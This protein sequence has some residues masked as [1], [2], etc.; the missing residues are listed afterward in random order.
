MVGRAN[1]PRSPSSS[2]TWSTPSKFCLRRKHIEDL[3]IQ[4][5]WKDHGCMKT[6]Q[7]YIDRTHRHSST[8]KFRKR[9]R[10]V[11]LKGVISHS[12]PARKQ[13]LS[14]VLELIC[15]L[16][17]TMP[18]KTT[19]EDCSKSRLKHYTNHTNPLRLSVLCGW[20][21]MEWRFGTSS[22]PSQLNVWQIWWCD[23]WRQIEVSVR[24]CTARIKL[25]RCQIAMK[26][27]KK[28]SSTDGN[29]SKIP[30]T[31]AFETPT[32]WIG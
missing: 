13:S 30:R 11:R 15:T 19:K 17:E 9:R 8:E 5:N 25:W 16:L 10:T 23:H 24:T 20:Y 29:L 32:A 18:N 31:T 4:E 28:K 21:E 22:N 14:K 7:G 1:E 6:R 3:H 2:S 26:W 12:K 27:K